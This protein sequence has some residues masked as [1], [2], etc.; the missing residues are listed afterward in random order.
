MRVSRYFHLNRPQPALDFVDVDVR[1]DT[2]LFVDPS[3]IRHMS[4]DWSMECVS[5]LQDFFATVLAHIR[6]GR[7]GRA[8]E[9]LV[10]L[11]EPNETRLGLSRRI[12]RGR[13]V[14]PKFA[15]AIWKALSASTAAA[16]GLLSDLEDMA[17]FIGGIDKDIVSD[18]TTNIIRG[19]LLRYTQGMCEIY[20][21]PMTPG[22]WP[23]PLWDLQTHKWTSVYE[24][25]PLAAGRKLLLV[26]K[27][28]VRRQI[29][30]SSSDYSTNY[31]MPYLRGLELNAMSSLVQVLK[32]GTRR[33]TN[34][35]LKEKYRLDKDELVRITLREPQLLSRYRENRL[36]SPIPPIRLEEFQSKV[37]TEPNWAS[38][39]ADVTRLTP[40]SEDASAYHKA[41]FGLL[42]ALF[43]PDLSFPQKERRIDEGRKRI[44]IVFTN[45]ADQGFFSWLGRHYTAPMIMVECKNYTEDPTNPELDQ[46][47]GRFSKSRGQ[48]GILVCR[49]I[50]DRVS[51]DRR[52]RDAANAGRGY[53][54]GLEDGDLESLVGLRAQYK[55]TEIFQLLKGHFE[56]L[57]M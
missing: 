21:I 11:G 19:P 15:E 1:G 39:A 34:K 44:D 42:S 45:T 35:A 55:W 48:F 33:V 2:K 51:F 20:G 56:R 46:L 27:V 32:N 7:N 13:G 53:I 6:E 41:V 25:M 24:Q 17:L 57:I 49:R 14:G 26:P 8:Q 18:I 12:A 54:L 36:S 50:E 16:T 23:G 30:Y 4:G 28:I 40:G 38:M 29:T 5:L 31:V 43:Y 47:A 22:V 52:C 37:A 10:E 3:A 9:L